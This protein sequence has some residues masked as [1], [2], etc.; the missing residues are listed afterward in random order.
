[1]VSSDRPA[2]K[3]GTDVRRSYLS[4]YLLLLHKV[5]CNELPQIAK[6]WVPHP[7]GKER[8]PWQ[9]PDVSKSTLPNR[10]ES[11]L[12]P[13]GSPMRPGHAAEVR[14]LLVSDGLHKGLMEPQILMVSLRSLLGTERGHRAERGLRVQDHF[15]MHPGETLCALPS[16]GCPLPCT[17]PPSCCNPGASCAQGQC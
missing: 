3:K 5:I 15:S 2:H 13:W 6:K 12:T 7:E 1:M 10:T 17:R 8:S 9:C 14:R 4:Q 16:P 11:F